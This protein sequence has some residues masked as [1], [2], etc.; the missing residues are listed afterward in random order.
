MPG[1]TRFDEV[2]RTLDLLKAIINSNESTV[3][4]DI[5]DQIEALDAVQFNRKKVNHRLANMST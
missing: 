1:A 2:E 3:I 5:R 4:G